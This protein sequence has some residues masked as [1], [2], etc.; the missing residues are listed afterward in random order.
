M[1]KFTL[2]LFIFASLFSNPSR[3]DHIEAADLTY[4]CMGGLTYQFTFRLYRDCSGIPIYS[5]ETI[6]AA[7]ASTAQSLSFNVDTI[8]GWHEVSP[9]CPSMLNQSFCNAGSLP[10]VQEFVYVGSITLPNAATDWIFTW[11]S[12]CRNTLVTN[13]IS[14]TSTGMR[15]EAHL[16][17]ILAPCNNSPTFGAIPVAYMCVNKPFNYTQS[18]VDIDGD[19]LVYTLV[20]PFDWTTGTWVTYSGTYTATYP[21]STST[22]TFPFNNQTGQM[23]FTPNIN[24]QAV[25]AV[26]VEEYRNGVVIGS[27]MRDMQMVVQTCSNNPPSIPA[28]ISNLVGGSLLDPYTIQVCPG[29]LINFDLIAIDPDPADNILETDNFLAAFPTGSETVTGSNPLTAHFTWTPTGLDVGFHTFAVTV[30]DT[31]CPVSGIQSYSFSIQ[32]LGGIA[33]NP[34]QTMCPGDPPVQLT[35]TGTSSATWTP[36]AGLSCTNCLN[37]VAN[38]SSTTTYTVT[39]T[40][41]SQCTNTATVTVF[42]QSP[43]SFEAGNDTTI[44]LYKNVHMN[45]VRTGSGNFTWTW[46]PAA[47]LSNANIQ[48]PMASPLV[49]TTY[50]VTATGAGGCAQMDVITI[51]V[52]PSPTVNAG[53]DQTILFGQT[54]QLNATTS[55]TNG[56]SWS[57]SSYLSD[58][59]ILSPQANPPVTTTYI[60]TANN[61]VGCPNSDTVVIEVLNCLTVYIP[62]TFT[63]NEDG[64]NDMLSLIPYGFSALADF[65]I[66]NR[67]G[68]LVFRTA[69]VSEGWDGKFNGR[70]QPAGAYVYTITATCTDGKTIEQKGNVLLLR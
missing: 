36:P 39:S 4:V 42:V 43:F 67:W 29:T 70:P 22:G 8:P 11:S 35:C 41:A 51:T 52:I 54:T 30:R 15:V 1:K 7:S 32:V 66:Y 69:D 17:N 56:F 9:L 10:G 28:G 14:P 37:P 58:P 20:Q 48:N 45:P 23:S 25:I 44:C 40:Q 61:L 12:C 13:I 34:N 19:S 62:N 63:P 60:F 57:P 16:N 5:P 55:G 3:A 47:G 68:E 53:P 49:T 18:A 27:T 46:T 6:T 31:A 2:A 50:S 64:K 26:L 65:S 24:Q 21:M 33:V 59:S 38:P